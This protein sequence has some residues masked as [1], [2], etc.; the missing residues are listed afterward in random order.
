MSD[1]VSRKEFEDL[2]KKVDSMSMGSAK[3]ERKPRAPTL[4]NKFV[5]QKSKE[6]RSKKPSLTQKEEIK[7][8][9]KSPRHSR[10]SLVLPK[11]RLVT[12]G[13]LW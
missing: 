9:E 6:I 13:V 4:Y 2:R 12:L 1:T 11:S 7:P 5:G 3:K 8:T 10:R